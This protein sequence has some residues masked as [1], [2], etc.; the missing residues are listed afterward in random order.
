LIQQKLLIDHRSILQNFVLGALAHLQL[1]RAKVVSG[2][3]EDARKAYREL[4]ALWIDADPDIP[5]LKRAR[6]EYAKMQ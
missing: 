1:G 3:I 4:F 5:I 6:L 2:D